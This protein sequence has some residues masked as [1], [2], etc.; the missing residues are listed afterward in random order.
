MLSIVHTTVLKLALAAPIHGLA[1]EQILVVHAGEHDRVGTPIAVRLSDSSSLALLNMVAEGSDRSFLAQVVRRGDQRWLEGV[2]PTMKKG[3]R[4]EFVLTPIVVSPTRPA[5]TPFEWLPAQPGPE[6]PRS[7]DLLLGERRVLRYMHTPFD[8]AD[9]ENTKKPFHHVFAPDGSQLLTKGPGGLYSHHRGIFFGYNKCRVGDK[10]FD[11]WHAAKGERSQHAEFLEEWTGAISGGHR[12]RIDWC[13]TEGEPFASEERSLRVWPQGPGSM[14]VDFH[15]VLRA[16]RGPVQLSGDRQHA[17]VQF[18]AAQEVAEN[19]KNSRY[20]RPARWSELDPAQQFNDD[21]HRGLPWNALRFSL[22]G[23]PYTVAYLSHPD[24]P[25]GAEFSERLY[26][27]F[28]EYFPWELRE[29][30]PLEARY[31]WWITEGHEVSANNVE[32]QWHDFSHPP[33]L[34]LLGSR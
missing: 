28:G 4:I 27:R 26:G 2:L 1:G 31:R 5:P 12:V 34:S 13:D 17:G 3:E 21:A 33:K 16:T 6:G 30:H 19:Q 23:K 25:D 7:R 15:T 11:I 20:L 24:N 8:P 10:S 32:R 14:L 22:Q 9:V 18:R 29:D